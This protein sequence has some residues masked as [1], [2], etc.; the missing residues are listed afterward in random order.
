MEHK[1]TK[2]NCSHIFLESVSQLTENLW[3]TEKRN[4]SVLLIDLVHN[5]FRACLLTELF[6]V[7]SATLVIH[8]K[9]Y[10]NLSPNLE[11][12]F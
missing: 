5:V 11:T 7:D 10:K 8:N 3:I 4:F 6:G 9:S 2:R 1:Y 12:K